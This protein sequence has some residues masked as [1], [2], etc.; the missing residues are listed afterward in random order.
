VNLTNPTLSNTQSGLSELRLFF[1]LS[2]TPHGLLD[3]A[4]P[5]LAALL[6]QGSF[7]PL[8]IIVLGLITAFA[9]YTA[10][11]ALNDLVD[12]HIDSRKVADGL[13]PDIQNDLDSI[14]VR[15]PLAYGLLPFTRGLLWT[16]AWTSVAL[17]GS[18]L[19]NPVCVGIF[20]GAILLEAIY[21]IMWKSGWGKVLISGVVKTSGAMAAVFA[22]DPHPSFP[23]LIL[24]FLWLFFWEIGG[25]NIPND[26]ADIEEDRILRATTIP[27]RFG[28]VLAGGAIFLSLLLT[29]ILNGISM[30]LSPVGARFAG[31]ATTLGAGIYLLLIPA[32]RLYRTKERMEALAL[33]NSASYYPI[34]LLA[35][36]IVAACT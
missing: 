22:V 24:L 2:R 8:R 27:V 26:W 25:Q 36:V 6:W 30:G 29:V 12:Y 11:Y 9:G 34:T 23:P 31:V 19:L 13:L 17:I 5:A 14:F 20:L 10:V 18:Y 4:T 32:Y 33:F 1:A 15:H 21:C 7:P 16:V 28:P 35:V 3:M